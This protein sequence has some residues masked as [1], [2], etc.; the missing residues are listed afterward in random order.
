MVVTHSVMPC[1]QLISLSDFSARLGARHA[2]KATG[3]LSANPACFGHFRISCL[4]INTDARSPWNSEKLC[5]PPA[6]CVFHFWW[7]AFTSVLLHGRL[8]PSGKSEPDTSQ[9]WKEQLAVRQAQL[10]LGGGKYQNGVSVRKQR[11]MV[12]ISEYGDSIDASILEEEDDE[13]GEQ[14]YPA[15]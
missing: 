13:M 11:S 2:V 3:A 6:C 10:N 9:A 1:C 14:Q 7:V 12:E 4:A 8:P 15:F 5:R